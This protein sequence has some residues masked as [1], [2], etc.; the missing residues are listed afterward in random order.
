VAAAAAKYVVNPPPFA[1][2][3]LSGRAI[4]AALVAE[5]IFTFALAYVVLNAATSKDQPGNSFYGLA[6]GFTVFVGA[7]S[8]GNIS[9]GGRRHGCAGAMPYRAGASGAAPRWSLVFELGVQGLRQLAEL[10]P[11]VVDL[12]QLGGQQ[13]TLLAVVEGVGDIRGGDG[14]ELGKGEAD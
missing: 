7:A 1:A 10:P 3:H 5:F 14:A 2:L 12:V 9:G 11:P 6:I 13:L 8:V 4:G